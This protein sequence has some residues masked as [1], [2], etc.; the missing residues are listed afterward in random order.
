[1]SALVPKY[2]PAQSAPG[3]CHVWRPKDGV[4]VFEVED[5]DRPERAYRTAT[6]V[7]DVL[8]SEWMKSEEKQ[9]DLP[10]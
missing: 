1:M 8:N 9:N 10:H 6:R 3:R 2:L 4:T 7:A 5:L